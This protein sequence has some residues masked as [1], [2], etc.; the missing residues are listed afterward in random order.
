MPWK[1]ILFSVFCFLKYMLLICFLVLRTKSSYLYNSFACPACTTKC[2]ILPY[3]H[4]YSFL[5]WNIFLF[6]S[7]PSS[8]SAPRFIIEFCGFHHPASARGGHVGQEA[9]KIERFRIIICAR[10][11]SKSNLEA[12]MRG[13]FHLIFSLPSVY[14]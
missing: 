1:L 12:Q 9:W 2:H 5:G 10:W 6:L 13:K 14:I 3:F 8:I 7:L 11:P 4:L